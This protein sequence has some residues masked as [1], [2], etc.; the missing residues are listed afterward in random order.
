[1]K[2]IALLAVLICLVASTVSAQATETQWYAKVWVVV[3][4]ETR[5][6]AIVEKALNDAMASLKKEGVYLA[7][8][9]HKGKHVT[10]SGHV[11]WAI[12]SAIPCPI[13][14][15][16]LIHPTFCKSLDAAGVTVTG[17]KHFCTVNVALSTKP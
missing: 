2:R 15:A 4:G 14:K 17:G 8:S 10:R 13:G 12:R 3:R 9:T 5:K 6:D 7:L 1:M 16:A 11:S